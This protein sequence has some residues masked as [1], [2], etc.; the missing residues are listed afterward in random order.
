MDMATQSKEHLVATTTVKEPAIIIIIIMRGIL[1]IHII[2]GIL[3]I[4]NKG[5]RKGR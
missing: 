3:G 5:S 4:Y 1:V 2:I